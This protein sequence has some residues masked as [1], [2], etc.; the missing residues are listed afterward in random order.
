MVVSQSTMVRN[1]SLPD[2]VISA[3]SGTK[4]IVTPSNDRN[5]VPKGMNISKLAF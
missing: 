3:K 2:V 1:L 5:G 4:S